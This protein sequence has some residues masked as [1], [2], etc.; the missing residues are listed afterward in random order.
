MNKSGKA[1]HKP[2]KISEYIK[3]E[4]DKIK[5]KS[6]KE[7]LAYFWDYYKWYVL[8]AVV[9]LALL[10]HTVTTSLNKKEVV[11][12]GILID[13]IGTVEE[14]AVLQ[15]FFDSAGINPEKQEVY[16]NTGLALNSGIPSIVTTSYQRIHAG[17]GAA[18]TDF[19]M[20]Y[21]YAIQRFAYDTSHVFADLRDILS[22]EI[23][24]EQ[25]EY[26]YY[27]D[28]AVI[29]KIKNEPQKEI[30]LPDPKKPEE[31]EQPVPVAVDISACGEFTSVYYTPDTAVYI[32]VVTN[33]PHEKLVAQ[34]IEFLLF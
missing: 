2:M 23:L 31:M 29:E 34:F 30:P 1:E 20:G 4:R 18:D 13:G 15:T 3:A 24:A 5:G 25:E 7:R 28:A 22:P 10:T 17:I 27:I 9:A 6:W 33:A 12:K 14:P 8:I 26:L 19:L 32:A 16:L 21:E 11:L